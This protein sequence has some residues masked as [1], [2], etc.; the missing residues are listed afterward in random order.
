[1][2]VLHDIALIRRTPKNRFLSSWIPF[3]PAD[4]FLVVRSYLNSDEL[5]DFDLRSDILTQRTFLL[6]VALSEEGTTPS[7][8]LPFRMGDVVKLESKTT[9]GR[10]F[11]KGTHIIH[12]VQFGE[13][14][15]EYST[16]R[17]AWLQHEELVLVEAANA[18]SLAQLKKSIEDEENEEFGFNE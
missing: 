17:M 6:L 12:Q 15:F 5:H 16:N 7:A 18:A 10:V 2:S 9:K 1:M 14:T 8:V 11:G 4:L 3:R 13:K